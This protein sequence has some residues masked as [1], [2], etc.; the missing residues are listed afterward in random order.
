MTDRIDIEPRIGHSKG[1]VE[2]GLGT[3]CIRSLTT[4]LVRDKEGQGNGAR[5]GSGGWHE[6]P[7]SHTV[8]CILDHL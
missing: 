7:K 4:N 3:K 2:A 8:H 6:T 5:R 1:N